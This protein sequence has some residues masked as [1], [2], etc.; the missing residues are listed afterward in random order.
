MNIINF[1]QKIPGKDD[2]IKHPIFEIPFRLLVIGA[3]GSGK[4][5]AALNIIKSLNGI[6]VDVTIVTKNSS[7][8]LYTYLKEKLKEQ[9]N[10]YDG[11]ENTPSLDKYDKNDHH[12]I[13]FDDMV[14]E[15]NQKSIIEYF[16]RARKLNCSVMYL[17]QSF[18]Q[19]PIL[20]RR[21]IGYL[22][23]K[24]L[25]SMNDLAR[26]VKECS[27]TESKEFV[28]SLYNEATKEK[29]SWL[30]L[31]LEKSRYYSGFEMIFSGSD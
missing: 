28:M 13:I 4:T 18:Y 1:Y 11:I 2:K 26:I 23:I 17:S 6:F 24:K 10:L 9:C 8:P 20:I 25:S 3:S 16:I 5:N 22:V 30:M 14:S 7:E 12:L 29:F 27:L 31:N 21:N 15:T 19:T